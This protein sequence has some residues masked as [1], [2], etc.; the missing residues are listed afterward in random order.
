LRIFA[1]PATA[2]KIA[3]AYYAGTSFP[4]EFNHVEIKDTLNVKPE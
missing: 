1:V 4:M 3:T 2:N